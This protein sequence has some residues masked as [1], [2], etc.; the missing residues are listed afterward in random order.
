MTR[1]LLFTAVM[2][3]FSSLTF[4][5]TTPVTNKNGL[6]ITPEAGDWVLGMNAAPILNYIGNMFNANDSNTVGSSFVNNNAIYGKYYVTADM[7]YR[8]SFRITTLSSTSRFLTNVDTVGTS[9]SYVENKMV[10]SGFGFYLSA[11][12]EKRK[13]HNR[14][15]GYYGVD[16]NLSL[17][18]ATPNLKYEY[19]LEMDSVNI[20]KGFV[21]SVRTIS[22]NSGTMFGVGI[23]PFIGVE[24]FVLPKLSIGAEFGWGL[25]LMTVGRGSLTREIWGPNP[26]SAA[27][28]SAYQR[29]DEVGKSTS[30]LWTTDNMG[31][32][33]RLL[34]HF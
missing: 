30:F 16:L 33:L 1:R 21:D 24:Y 22:A 11:G 23:R 14:L 27:S 17:G 29:T 34:Y 2:L 9:P 6:T 28:A 18:A 31:G 12:I 32:A 3:G 15:Q 26:P 4:A 8:G 5:Q 20:A 13:G 19:A 25:N 10:A 7:A